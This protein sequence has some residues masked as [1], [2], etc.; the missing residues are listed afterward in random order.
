MSKGTAFLYPHF[1]FFFQFFCFLIATDSW[2]DQD[3][4]EILNALAQNFVFPT[5]GGGS[6]M[7]KATASLHPHSQ[8]FSVPLFSHCHWRFRGPGP[9]SDSKSPQCFLPPQTCVGAVS[10]LQKAK[11][12]F[13]SP[14]KVFQCF[15]PQRGRVSVF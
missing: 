14:Q 11:V 13:R 9:L 10:D 7:I 12:P 15:A 1:Q 6:A 2:G 3:C 4:V 8:F 5:G